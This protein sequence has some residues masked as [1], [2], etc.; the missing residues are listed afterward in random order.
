MIKVNDFFTK[1]NDQSQI[2]EYNNPQFECYSVSSY[3]SP[4]QRYF[5]P[6]HWHEDL[7]YFYVIEGELEFHVNGQTII[8][9]AKEGIL[10]NSKRIYS[11]KIS[12]EEIANAGNVGKTLCA[13]LFKEYTSR[14]PGEY[15]IRYRIQKSIELLTSSEAS[16]TDIAYAVGFSSASHYTQTFREI[17]GYTPLKYRSNHTA[18]TV[19]YH[20]INGS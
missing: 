18:N 11:E 2:L 15:L 1:R 3:F 12:L 20:L 17:T 10:V 13:R 19:N 4:N 6:D 14:T 9:H 5:V 7:E 8:I 16:I